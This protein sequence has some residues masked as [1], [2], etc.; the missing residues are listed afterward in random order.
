MTRNE[1]IAANI[2]KRV[3]ANTRYKFS[4]LH[5]LALEET[6]LMSQVNHPPTDAQIEQK[7][8]AQFAALEQRVA[9]LESLPTAVAE[10]QLREY[11]KKDADKEA[12][13]A[14]K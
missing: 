9:A 8:A 12:K 5:R 1:A 14:G 7:R 6:A 2:A 4:T 13:K 10:I 3:A 11:A